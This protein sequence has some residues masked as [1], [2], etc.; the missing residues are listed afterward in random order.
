MSATET[1]TYQTD[2][3]TSANLDVSIIDDTPQTGDF[4]TNVPEGQMQDF[5]LVFTLDV[6]GSMSGAH[7]DGLV[8]LEDGSSTTRLQ[9]AKD[10]LKALAQEYHE[11]SDNVTIHLV[12][13]SSDAQVLNGGDPFTDLA[14]TLAAIDAMDGSGG[15]NYEDGLNKTIDRVRR[16]WR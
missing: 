15:T 5:H 14:S 2:L 12:T 8:Y 7:F 6:S 10:A 4:S 13:F 16:Q 1:F 3:G 9:M 11:Q